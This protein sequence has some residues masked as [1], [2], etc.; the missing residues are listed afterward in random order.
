VA[1]RQRLDPKQVRAMLEAD[2]SVVEILG[3]KKEDAARFVKL[4]A[5]NIKEK[6]FDS[7]EAAAEVATACD[8]KLAEAWISLGVA[9]AKLKNFAEAV[10]CYHKALELR[11]DDIACW[12]DLG[13]LYVGL[14]DYPRAAEALKQAM[15]LDPEAEHPFG[16]RARAIVGRALSML[17]GK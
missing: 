5:Q 1:K 7:A 2:K 11:P 12:T 4:A 17:R 3:L 15:L 14:L 16:R 8:P 10:P 13:E 6:D 9:R